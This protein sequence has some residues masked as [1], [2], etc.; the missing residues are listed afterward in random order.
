MIKNER[1]RGAARAQRSETATCIL[2]GSRRR[3]RA[4][5]TCRTCAISSLQTCDISTVHFQERVLLVR[6]GPRTRGDPD[7]QKGPG[8]P[9][10]GPRWRQLSRFTQSFPT[11]FIKLAGDSLCS[12]P[13]LG[14]L[15]TK[16]M[17]TYLITTPGRKPTSREVGSTRQAA[18]SSMVISRSNS[19]LTFG[20][21]RYIVVR[22]GSNSSTNAGHY[23]A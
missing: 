1:Y 8:T 19:T 11:F 17:L 21:K 6:S 10:P 23:I 22:W 9:S 12:D 13:T 14:I 3:Y 7:P 2:P 18:F 5:Y 4:M 20:G 16:R 15:C